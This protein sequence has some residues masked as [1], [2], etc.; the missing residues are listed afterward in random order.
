M[1]EP[2]ITRI[3][4]HEILDSRGVPTIRA[5]V[6]LQTGAITK[7]QYEKSLKGLSEKMG[8]TPENND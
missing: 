6:F 8:F 2:I 3:K 7:E 4:A 5:E 1:S